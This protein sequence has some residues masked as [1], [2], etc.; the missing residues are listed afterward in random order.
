MILFEVAAGNYELVHVEV[1]LLT[2]EDGV[3]DWVV[4]G[5][6][7]VPMRCRAWQFR[8]CSIRRRSTVGCR[9]SSAEAY[10]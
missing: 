7:I 4:S 2:A 10:N 1:D 5:G 3:H 6:C 8:S 9:L